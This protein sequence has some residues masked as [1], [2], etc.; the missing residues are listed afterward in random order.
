MDDTTRKANGE[1]IWLRYTT[2]YIHEGRT[3]TIEIEVPV[4]IGASAETREQLLREA[5]AGMDQLTQHIEARLARQPRISQASQVAAA[6]QAISTPPPVERPV[7][8]PSAPVRNVEKTASPPAQVT[9]PPAQA[10]P[11][12]T[13]SNR[14]SQPA[15]REEVVVPPTRDSIGAS[16]PSAPIGTN[17]AVGNL[18]ITGF[19]DHIKEMG[20]DSK[21]A[22]NRLNIKSLSGI[23][24]RDALRQLQHQ[25][26]QETD[27]SRNPGA[28]SRTPSSP[29]AQTTQRSAENRNT[30]PSAPSIQPTV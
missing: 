7:V 20:L 21:Q 26:E 1:Y 27:R 6:Q 4:P 15:A 19:L 14:G 16:M 23:N 18:S 10:V 12:S 17:D 5:E 2:Q 9:R 13:A 3:Q 22:M 28:V 25:I 24:L 11:A 30:T 29:A 8:A